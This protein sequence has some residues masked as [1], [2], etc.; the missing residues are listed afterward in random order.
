MKTRLGSLVTA[1]VVG[2]LATVPLANARSGGMSPAGSSR[3]SGGGFSSWHGSDGRH[4]DHDRFHNNFGFFF[5]GPGPFWYPYY[6]PPYYYD[7]YH[8]YPPPYDYYYDNPPARYY[9]D[10]TPGYP[11]YDERSYLMLGHDAGKAL[12][13]KTASRDWFVEYV[14]AYIINAPP[15]AR[16]DF[17]RGFISGYGENAES[18]L[19]KARQD[20]QQQIS[21]PA[22]NNRTSSQGER[23][24]T[25]D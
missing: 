20:A 6:C 19:K 25:N 17:R 13:S 5:F 22:P 8:D 14:R 2:V 18:V 12:R 1:V 23:P 4:F 21:S 7:D 9:S 24:R 15:S 16:D 10:N 11:Q 3:P